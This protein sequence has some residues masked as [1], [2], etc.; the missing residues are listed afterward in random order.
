MIKR[1]VLF[2]G[3]LLTLNSCTKRECQFGGPYQFEISAT[4]SPAKVTYQIDDTITV[5]SI[6]SDQVYELITNKTYPLINFKFYPTFDVNEISDSIIDKAALNNF[7]VII[8]TIKYNL[9]EFIYSDGAVTYDGEYLYK[10][11]E[12]SLEYKLIPKVAGFYSLFQ[13]LLGAINEDYDFPEKCKNKEIQIRTILNNRADNNINLARNSPNE[14]YNTW[15]FN[16]PEERFKH[17]GGY[18]FYVEE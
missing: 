8:D 18:I 15:L 1:V 5:G 7:E 14:L 11:S 9:N 10:N 2:L 16:D 6:F 17:I 12:Y 3:I 13:H 4:L